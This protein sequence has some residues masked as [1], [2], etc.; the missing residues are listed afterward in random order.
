MQDMSKLDPIYNQIKD[1]ITGEVDTSI[2][3]RDFYSHDAS[4]FE[5]L[6]QAIAFPKDS[7][8]VQALVSFVAKNKAKHPHLSLT[9][10]SAGTDMTGGSINESILVDFTKHFDRTLSVTSSEAVVLPGR[11]YRDFEKDTFRKNALMPSFPASR[12][13]CTV[14]GMVANNSGGE[15]S[16]EF[17]KT[18][19]FVKQLKVVL[20]DGKEYIIKP[21]TKKE[22][23]KKMAKKTFEGT[24]YKEL[25]EL[26][27]KNY[28]E[29][30]AAKPNVTKDSTGY[31]LWNVWDREKG[32]FD[33]TQL[34]VGSQGT[35]G[36]VT[37]ITFRLVPNP[38]ES[39]SLL[40]FLNHMENLGEVIN[41]VLTHKPATFEGFDNH[42]LLLSFKL[43]FYFRQ[44]LGWMGLIKLGLQLLPV[45]LNFR[46]GI[47]KMVLIAQFTAD[48]D[49]E[50][51]SKVKALEADMAEFGH[52]ALFE[53]D[54]NEDKERKFFI[55][56]RES[57]NL[58]RKKVK[59]KHTAPFID[60]F[61]VPPEHLPEFLPKLRKIIKKYKLLAT[62]QGHFGDGN[63]HVIPLMKI[64]LESDR[65]KLEPC[66]RE[67]NALVVS[68]GGSMSG[69][70]NDGMSRGPWLH[71]QYKPHI[72]AHFRS[73]KHILDP[74][75]IFNPHKKT[76]S[77]WHYSMSHIREHF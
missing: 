49:E 17:G 74:D 36:L 25:F 50:V 7:K 42:T 76:D 3:A 72:M 19:Q 11:H 66:M 16:L 4:L 12:E 33:L 44:T 54:E 20:A 10:R 22:L 70:H 59:D 57:F 56:R 69:E 2:Q 55:L 26:L 14:G 65:A 38:K 75:N 39:G 77:D 24:V 63:F 5:I 45:L 23:D 52:D 9:G 32:I 35:L 41:K 53:E 21:L 29:I 64:E 27:D 15:K 8:D 60:D 34:F 1:V 43:F 58:L 37:E 31:H 67:V 71:Q 28:D 30:K 48:T 46:R 62:L 68:Y 61:I 51:V 47:P 73:A 40:I 13:L 6:P 18:E